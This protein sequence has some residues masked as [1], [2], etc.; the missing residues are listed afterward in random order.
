MFT[1]KFLKVNQSLPFALLAFDGMELEQGSYCVLFHVAACLLL[2]CCV[3]HYCYVLPVQA[4][5]GRRI[6]YQGLFFSG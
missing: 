4:N 2:W 5:T 6:I 3:H 1:E